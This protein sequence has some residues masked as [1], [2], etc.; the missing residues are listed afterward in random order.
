LLPLQSCQPSSVRARIFS[1]ARWIVWCTRDR[2]WPSLNKTDLHAVHLETNE[3]LV[4]KSNP[5]KVIYLMNGF[6]TDEGSQFTT[7]IILDQEMDLQ[8]SVLLSAVQE[9]KM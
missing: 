4:E 9:S 2:R 3:S 8:K 5:K 7:G 1:P 6:V